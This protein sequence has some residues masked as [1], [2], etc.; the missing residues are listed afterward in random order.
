VLNLPGSLREALLGLAYA[1]HAPT[2]LLLDSAH[3]IAR[4][5]DGIERY[6]LGGLRLGEPAGTQVWFLE[7]LLPPPDLPFTLPA[8][9]GLAVCTNAVS[10]AAVVAVRPSFVTSPCAS[11]RHHTVATACTSMARYRTASSLRVERR[12]RLD[13]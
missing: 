4:V 12:G 13:R 5:G 1:E 9:V 6:G 2:Y 8:V 11:S 7:G 10:A 3:R